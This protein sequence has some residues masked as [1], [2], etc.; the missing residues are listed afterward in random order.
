M[1]T[2]KIK[3]LLLEARKAKKT[4]EIT[5]YSTLLGELVAIGKNNGNRET[6][7]DEAVRHI[8][9]WVSNIDETIR[10]RGEGV[11][12][13]LLYE[14]VLCQQFLPQQLDDVVLREIIAAMID[15]LGKN[16]GIVMKTLKEQ[17]PNQYDGKLAST[18]FKELSNA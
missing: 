18:I 5:F 8:K 14:K 6:T 2:N 12:T 13:E 3:D 15:T 16:Q 17:Y 4:A 10:A 9:K 7:D 11:C 1:I